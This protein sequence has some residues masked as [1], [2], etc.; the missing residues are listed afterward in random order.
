MPEGKFQLNSPFASHNSQFTNTLTTEVIIHP[1][2]MRFNV[3]K[4]YSE[5]YSG[6]ISAIDGQFVKLL[7]ITAVRL[8]VE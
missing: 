1:R 4:R 5:P 3:Y 6:K 7:G 2:M 8:L